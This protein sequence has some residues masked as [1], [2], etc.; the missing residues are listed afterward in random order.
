MKQDSHNY[1]RRKGILWTALLLCVLTGITSSAQEPASTFSLKVK[2]S[3]EG[4][5]MENALI[6][7]TKNG[8]T[9]KV[10]D[11]K[12]KY[13]LDLE[14][15]ADFLLTFTKPGYI[16]KSL[17]VDTHVPNGHE[18]DEFNQ[19]IATV[20]LAKQ[21]EDQEITYTQPVG[22]IKYSGMEG[23]FDA[24]KDYS[25]KAQAM[26]ETAEAHPKPKPKPPAPNPKPE[27]KPAPV[28]TTPPSNPVA[29]PVK[30]PEYKPEPPKPKPVVTVPDV[31]AK[32]IVKNKEEKIIQEDRRKITIV[33]VNIDGTDY[34]YKKEE[35]T[36]GGLYFYKNGKNIT[37]RTF[38]KETE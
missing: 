13:V 27:T 36:W 34:V 9:Y 18:K 22:R 28:Q 7:I 14:L 19:Y 8:S 6:T 29:V 12:S 17:A 3:I 25:Q 30:Q 31:P 1:N 38:E 24:D 15:G 2:F 23:Q 21:P 32:A 35:Y 26:V 37:E 5:G 10:I 20:E 33:T 4:G 11:S 16:T